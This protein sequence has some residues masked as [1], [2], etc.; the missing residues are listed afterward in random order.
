VIDTIR[1]SKISSMRNMRTSLMLPEM[2][3]TGED[4]ILAYEDGGAYVVK[5]SG[6]TWHGPVRCGPARPGAVSKT[7]SS[8]SHIQWI[9]D[10]RI[11]T[12]TGGLWR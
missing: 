6:S 1:F 4:S 9:E 5:Q 3:K 11:M 8:P 10:V 7:S 2:S 12:P